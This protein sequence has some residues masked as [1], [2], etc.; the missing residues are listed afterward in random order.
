M[1]P[2]E[3]KLHVHVAKWVEPLLHVAHVPLA[4]ALWAVRRYGLR[5]TAETDGKVQECRQSN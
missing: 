4:L 5:Y 1:A 3:M 2:V